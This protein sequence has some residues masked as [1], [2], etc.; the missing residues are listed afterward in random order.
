MWP[1]QTFLPA[2]A[3]GLRVESKA[4][5][6]QVRTLTVARVGPLLG[7]VSGRLMAELDE[8]LRLHLDL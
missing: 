3:T 8:V 5:A 1:F 6:E 7:Q 2:D 4:Q